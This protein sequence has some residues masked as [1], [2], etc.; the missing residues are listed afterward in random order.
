[1]RDIEGCGVLIGLEQAEGGGDVGNEVALDHVLLLDG[2]LQEDCMSLDLVEHVVL[3]AQVVDTVDGNAS[4]VGQPNGIAANVGLVADSELV[5]VDG[6]A[7]FHGRLSDVSEL[8]ALNSPDRGLVSRRVEH[9]VRPILSFVRRHVVDT[10]DSN[11][12]GQQTDFCDE[13]CRARAFVLR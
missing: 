8:N 11:I 10:P 6:V 2:I 9:Q 12:S 5:E 13:V 4:V 1:M 3:Y 7:P